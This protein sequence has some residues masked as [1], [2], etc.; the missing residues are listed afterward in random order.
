[1]LWN[2]LAYLLWAMGVIVSFN[3]RANIVLTVSVEEQEI[4]TV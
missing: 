3:N 2:T 4:L 1:L